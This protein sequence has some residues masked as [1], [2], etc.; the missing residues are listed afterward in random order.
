MHCIED[1]VSYEPLEGPKQ[2]PEELPRNGQEPLDQIRQYFPHGFPDAFKNAC[3][4]S[5]KPENMF[6]TLFD[7]NF[8]NFMGERET[9]FEGPTAIPFEEYIK[10]IEQLRCH[11]ERVDVVFRRKAKNIAKNLG[12]LDLND[13]FKPGLYHD[14]GKL[15][16]G[17]FNVLVLNRTLQ[18]EILD[19]AKKLHVIIGA[20]MVVAHYMLHH[21][22][23]GENFEE[24]DIFEISY[25]L[26]AVLIHH[27]FTN[28]YPM[29]D[30]LP[31]FPEPV[32]KLI[33]QIYLTAKIFIENKGE[34]LEV[35]K[36]EAL[37]KGINQNIILAVIYSIIICAADLYVSL[38]E[39]RSY[40]VG[41]SDQDAMRIVEGYFSL[42]RYPD[43][44]NALVQA[45]GQIPDN[46]FSSPK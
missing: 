38:R 39:D 26:S 8:W 32:K 18:Q 23:D 37:K 41:M 42:E 9:H 31:E 11:C 21:G 20:R 3:Q 36:N 25:S 45:R 33:F 24:K 14:I 43:V 46:I 29:F 1:M 6:E 27:L 17:V 30:E 12:L 19:E 5:P 13:E 15:A 35:S 34:S 28:N 40:K 2:P 44:Y 7:N 16:P 4:H 22:L 10:G